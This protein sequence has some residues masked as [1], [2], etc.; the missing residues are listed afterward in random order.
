MAAAFTAPS[1][2]G[3]APPR[4]LLAMAGVEKRFDRGTLA[5]SGLD[6][7]VE[8]GA[9]VSL[10]GPSGCGKSMILRLMAGLAAP[11][12]GTITWAGASRP[13]LSFVFQEPT[14]MPWASV[15]DNVLLPLKVARPAPA[16]ALAKAR[17]ALAG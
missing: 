3:A 1:A 13:R 2:A 5:L 15:L 17:E 11:T 10:L 14:L 7:T 12:G 4:P 6:L 8:A 16:A 9:L